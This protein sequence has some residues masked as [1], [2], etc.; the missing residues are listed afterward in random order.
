[1]KYTCLWS[2]WIP[3]HINSLIILPSFLRLIGD[4]FVFEIWEAQSTA[5]SIR[6]S[7]IWCWSQA[8]E[9]GLT[10]ICSRGWP[11]AALEGVAALPCSSFLDDSIA[12]FWSLMVCSQ[13]HHSILPYWY[14]SLPNSKHHWACWDSTATH[15]WVPWNSTG[16]HV[17]QGLEAGVRGQ[18]GHQEAGWSYF[19]HTQK[20]E[21][22]RTECGTIC[23]ETSK[24]IPVRYLLYPSGLHLL[25]VH[26]LPK[27][28]HW[29]ETKWL[30]PSTYG[31]HFHS[32]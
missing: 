29:L 25:K 2:P 7:K 8:R 15:H 1:M 10:S 18:S 12:A 20:A 6:W 16:F 14:S 26:Y 23:C 28:Q 9:F 3:R 24:S 30:N 4:S 5:F 21:C 17:G 27:E 11:E 31:G 19:I 13:G 22:K 32:N